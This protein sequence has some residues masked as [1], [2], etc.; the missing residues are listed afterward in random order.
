MSFFGDTF[1][2]KQAENY[3][4]WTDLNLSYMDEQMVVVYDRTS[5]GKNISV[6]FSL[7]WLISTEHWVI[8][9]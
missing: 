5:K 7:I 8:A 9:Y 3:I 2:A 1:K 6:A 4:K